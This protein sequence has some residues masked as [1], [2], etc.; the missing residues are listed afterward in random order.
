MSLVLLLASSIFIMG[1]VVAYTYFAG[2][3]QKIQF[4]DSLDAKVYLK[5]ATPSAIL[6][7][8]FLTSG[9][10]AALGLYGD[11]SA[12]LIYAM[13]HKWI[14]KTLNAES[15][16][17]ASN[18]SGNRLHLTFADY[19]AP[20]LHLTLENSHERDNWMA[21]LQPYILAKASQ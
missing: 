5:N 18:I 21:V 16:R 11:G 13:G 6:K 4:T 14:H 10:H 17:K 20:S 19:T 3:G 2:F 12:R 15:V 7:Q 9:R 8:H 1:L